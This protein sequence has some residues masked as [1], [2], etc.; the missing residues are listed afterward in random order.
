MVCP[1]RNTSYGWKNNPVKLHLVFTSPVQVLRCLRTRASVQT[2]YERLRKNNS[3]WTA[4]T[5]FVQNLRW[6]VRVEVFVPHVKP[7]QSNYMLFVDFECRLWFAKLPK[8]IYIL[9]LHLL[10]DKWKSSSIKV[11]EVFRSPV[12]LQLFALPSCLTLL[13]F[14]CTCR[15]ISAFISLHFCFQHWP[16]ESI[17]R[18][19]V[20]TYLAK[21]CQKRRKIGLI[22]S[23]KNHHSIFENITHTRLLYIERNPF[24]A[25]NQTLRSYSV[26]ISPTK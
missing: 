23:F 3:S 5:N 17:V 21:Y 15:V 16:R 12:G 20:F 6:F 8:T 24:P 25:K 13:P 1:C 2:R 19:N 10:C 4:S 26:Y 22:R 7:I 9:S 18:V 14:Y 11:H